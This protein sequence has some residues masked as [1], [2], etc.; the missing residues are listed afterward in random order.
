[1][2]KG[3]GEK[4]QKEWIP[5]PWGVN[6]YLA[7]E[8][9]NIFARRGDGMGRGGN[10]AAWQSTDHWRLMQPDQFGKIAKLVRL[11]Q[12]EIC[13]SV[14]E[15]ENW[16]HRLKRYRGMS[17]QAPQQYYIAGRMYWKTSAHV[18]LENR[19]FLLL[20]ANTTRVKGHCGRSFQGN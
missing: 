14:C 16:K 5:P 17:D 2:Q 7:D 18:R 3:V 9:G 20:A 11:H 13:Y 10:M 4:R 6:I 15:G 19:Y 1:M 8:G 12:L